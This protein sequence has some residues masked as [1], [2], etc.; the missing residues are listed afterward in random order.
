MYIQL[1]DR[2]NMKCDHCCM[3]S[4]P[5]RKRFMS[6]GVYDACLRFATNY[7]Q[8]IPSLTGSMKSPTTTRGWGTGTGCIT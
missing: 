2:C 4:H 3:D 8:P 5:R 1:T 7:N 6:E